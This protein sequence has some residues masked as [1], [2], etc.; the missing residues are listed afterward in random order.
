MRRVSAQ[1]GMRQCTEGHA[2][3]HRMAHVSPWNGVY[4]YTEWQVSNRASRSSSVGSYAAESKPLR[5]KR[6]GANGTAGWHAWSS[7][8]CVSTGRGVASYAVP[9][10]DGA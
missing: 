5:Y 1:T 4:N 7:T 3:V 8:H 9:V 2:S 10:L 6:Y